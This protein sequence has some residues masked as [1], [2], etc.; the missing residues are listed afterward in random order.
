MAE[1]GVVV[2]THLGI[3]GNQA[4]VLGHDERVDL[5]QGGIVVAEHPV[6]RQQDLL[7]LGDQRGI[8][9]A[10]EG[11]FSGLEGQEANCRLDDDPHDGLWILFG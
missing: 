1:Q 3:Q 2:E 10:G 4:T 11:R 5:E 8:Q 9:P 7:G 6:G